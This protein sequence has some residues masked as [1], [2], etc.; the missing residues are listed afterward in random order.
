VRVCS[1]GGSRA[2]GPTGQVMAANPAEKHSGS[3]TVLTDFARCA[4]HL[5]VPSQAPALPLRW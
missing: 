4:Q 3:A 5:L 1:N 2:G